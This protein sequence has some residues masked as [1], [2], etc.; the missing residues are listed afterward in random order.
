MQN[1]EQ[2]P[3]INFKLN[4][5]EVDLLGTAHISKASAD[6]VK[7]MLQTGQYDCVAVELCPSRHN[8]IV[9]PDA[10]A[11][12]DLFQ[13]IK[14]GKA[15]MVT[16]N[17]ALGAFQQRMA[18][19]F[20]IKPGAEMRM[21]IDIAAELKIPV[22]LIDREITTTLKRVYGNVP[23]WQ[24]MNLASGL[25]GSVVS[26]QKVTEEEIERL[27]EGDILESTFAQFAEEAEN[28]YLPLVD[29]RDQYMAARIQQE[30]LTGEYGR[31]LA[32]VGA[33]HMKGI[34]NYIE[35]W[36]QD[37]EGPEQKIARLDQLPKPKRWPRFIPWAIVALII[38]GF[39]VGFS[40]NADLGLQL[41]WYWI[42]IN[43]AL[44]SLGALIALAHPLTIIGAFV[45]APITSLN[46]TIGAGMVTA[47]METWLRKPKVQDFSH[48]RQDTTHFRGWWKNRVTRVLLV[49]ILCTLGSAAGTYI[50]GFKIF[51][52]IATT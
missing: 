42:V 44:C 45:A 3:L 37:E 19:E 7:E 16:A 20:G 23:W 46:P 51:E 1:S 22:L 47:A 27:K 48:L 17:L 32:V 29:E 26:R 25:L 31:M 43:G 41:V 35:K 40:R 6:K 2:E 10:L 14:E 50:A 24:K 33:G 15:L 11:K 4:H 5:V 34:G 8:S 36:R 52:S 13:V 30:D 18:D 12:M 38:A 28:I 9:N 49:F 21:A 39:A